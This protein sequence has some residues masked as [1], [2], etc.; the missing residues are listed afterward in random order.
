MD[1]LSIFKGSLLKPKDRKP[2]KDVNKA[3]RT[4]KA[5]KP[6]ERKT[7]LKAKTPLK[8]SSGL[9]CGG[10]IKSKPKQKAEVSEKVL[11]EKAEKLLDSLGLK[12]EHI[13]E[14]VSRGIYWSQEQ[15][16]RKDY[17]SYLTGSP[18]L[19][20]WH[21]LQESNYNLSLVL[22]LKTELGQLSQG[23]K[24]WI[25]EAPVN[26]QVCKGWQEIKKE[27]IDFSLFCKGLD[28]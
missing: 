21:P 20:V 26:V 3:A 12:W 9:K 15:K 11:Q 23:Q 24:N 22:E 1:D 17:S 6:I 13:P 7:P 25:R 18:D 27:I 8:S 28:L 5:R 14:S 19:K 10:A 4:L 16:T 2:R